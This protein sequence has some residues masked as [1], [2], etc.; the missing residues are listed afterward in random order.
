MNFVVAVPNTGSAGP[1]WQWVPAEQHIVALTMELPAPGNGDPVWVPQVLLL[2][3]F[4]DADG[5]VIDPRRISVAANQRA[6][7]N[8]G[9]YVPLINNRGWCQIGPPTLWADTSIEQ[10]IATA[11]AVVGPLTPPNGSPDQALE[12]EHWEHL[13][14]ILRAHGVTITPQ[15]LPRLPHHVAFSARLQARF[16]PI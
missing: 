12:Y 11:R 16:N 10:I 2:V 8:T 3:T 14:K 6:L 4:I 13:A 9:S 1:R 7:L 15:D 5:D